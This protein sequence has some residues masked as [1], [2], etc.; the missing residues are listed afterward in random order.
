MR[1][2]DRSEPRVD[3]L[4]DMPVSE[5][6]HR[7]C[8]RG[9]C[10]AA[11]AAFAV[12]CATPTPHGQSDLCNIFDQYPNWYDHARESE[13]EW[14]TPIPVLM[15]FV[16]HEPSFRSHARPPFEWA[17]IIPRGRPSSARGYPQAQDPVWGEYQAERGRLF[18]SRSD[19]KDALDFIGWYNYKTW[20]ELDIS[21]HDAQRLYLAYHEGR[22]G[23]RR[24]TWRNKS[25]VQRTA[26]QV[27]H[28]A[29]RYEAQLSRC[30]AD[31][32]CDGW[33]EFWPF[34]S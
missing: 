33:F 13:E 32:H 10:F 5:S 18:R 21:R 14:G 4:I 30:E 29:K 28:T 3:P 8:T 1:E 25:S 31:F 11:V 2:A 26:L 12:G 15:A 6:M 27:E 7:V 22:A 34:C 17:W 24:G 20:R 16:F 19:M 9:A 23:Y